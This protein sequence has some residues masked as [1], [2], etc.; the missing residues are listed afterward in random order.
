MYCELEVLVELYTEVFGRLFRREDS[1]YVS[2]DNNWYAVVAGW[3]IRDFPNVC[4]SRGYDCVTRWYRIGFNCVC[5]GLYRDFWV[6]KVDQF[7]L[8]RRELGGIFLSPVGCS[9]QCFL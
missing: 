7:E 4:L 9:L 1:W 2:W 5:T 3:I 6:Y 8:V